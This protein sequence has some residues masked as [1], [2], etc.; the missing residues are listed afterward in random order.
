MFVVYTLHLY[1][2]VFVCLYLLL[3]VWSFLEVLNI[4][5]KTKQFTDIPFK[6]SLVSSADT[7][8]ISSA[9]SFS[10]ASH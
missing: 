7:V 4:D 1:E 3:E 10:I 2:K 8:S 5:F 6:N 9:L